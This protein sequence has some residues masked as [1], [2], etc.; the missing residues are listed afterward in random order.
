M[1]RC[2]AGQ[3]PPSSSASVAVHTPSVVVV[4]S[5]ML[6]RVVRH[7]GT[8]SH[9]RPLCRA[10]S[11]AMSK[12]ASLGEATAL[13]SAGTEPS[14]GPRYTDGVARM[15]QGKATNINPSQTDS[16]RPQQAH[17]ST[18]YLQGTRDFPSRVVGQRDIHSPY[19]AGPSATCGGFTGVRDRR[20]CKLSPCRTRRSLKTS[21]SICCGVWVTT[22]TQGV[23]LWSGSSRRW[24]QLSG[25]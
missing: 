7:Q 1:R 12:L 24:R 14:D 4:E 22:M 8:L 17:G 25:F 16:S 21:S 18:C 20:T 5:E 3:V 10:Q 13:K 11:S 23:Y 19:A 2:N 15:H 6:R 9:C